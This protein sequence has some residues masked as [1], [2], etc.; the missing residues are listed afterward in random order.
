[1]EGTR[2][3]STAPPANAEILMA[4]LDLSTLTDEQFED[5]V[6]AIFRAKLLP[7][8]ANGIESTDLTNYAVISVSRSGRGPDHGRALLVTTISTDCIAP[9]TTR[10]LVQCKH[11][12]VSGKSVGPGDFAEDF[13]FNEIVSQHDA[14]G[15]LLVCSTRPGTRLQSRFDK[16]A[17]ANAPRRFV[18]WDAAKVGEEILRH[19]KVMRQF[20]PDEYQRQQKLIESSRIE[21]WIRQYGGAVSEDAKAAL[22][23]ILNTDETSITTDEGETG[24]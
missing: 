7:S 19:E 11:K 6:E 4:L 18:I 9:Q 16:L 3:E 14:N 24:G 2:V 17:S 13:G 23:S 10:W 20:F 22:S 8:S 1:L 15:Y 21:T 5:L 12:A